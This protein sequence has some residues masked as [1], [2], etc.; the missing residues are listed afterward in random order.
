M[1]ELISNANKVFVVLPLIYS[2]FAYAFSIFVVL[3]FVFLIFSISRC[4]SVAGRSLLQIWQSLK[5]SRNMQRK[6]I[7]FQGREQQEQGDIKGKAYSDVAGS[8]DTKMSTRNSDR[9]AGPTQAKNVRRSQSG[10]PKTL[11]SLCNLATL[12]AFLHLP[13]VA[14]AYELKSGVDMTGHGTIIFSMLFLIGTPFVSMVR[15]SVQRHL[16][17]FRDCV[18][19]SLAKLSYMVWVTGGLLSMVTIMASAINDVNGFEVGDDITKV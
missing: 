12:W 2:I 10:R 17:S 8:M 14:A 18:R 3:S 13:T 1:M 5:K 19:G 9:V 4:D 7:H 6:G 16:K 15:Q 11:E